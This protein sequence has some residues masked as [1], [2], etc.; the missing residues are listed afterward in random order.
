[1]SD[2]TFTKKVGNRRTAWFT[3]PVVSGDPLPTD[4]YKNFAMLQ[5]TEGNKVSFIIS[6]GAPSTDYTGAGI[7]SL[8]FD[9]TNGNIYLN[10]DGVD[11]WDQ[12]TA[13]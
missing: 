10:H 5:D 3:G 12:I 6:E 13:S 9:I 8:C 4:G 2:P 11:D 1:M 7:C